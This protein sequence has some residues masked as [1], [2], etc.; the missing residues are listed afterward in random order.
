MHHCTRQR[1]LENASKNHSRW[2]ADVRN[3]NAPCHLQ[4]R[5]AAPFVQYEKRQCCVAVFCCLADG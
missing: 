2:V 4:T 1:I 3:V 5:R